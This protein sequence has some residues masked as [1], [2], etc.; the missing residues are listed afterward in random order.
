MKLLSEKMTLM[1]I[2]RHLLITLSKTMKRQLTEAWL[3]KN[4]QSHTYWSSS[5]ASLSAKTSS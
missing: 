4:C 5:M 1:A 3:S 2:K